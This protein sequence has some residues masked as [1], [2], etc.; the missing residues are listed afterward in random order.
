MRYGLIK[1]LMA[2]KRVGLLL[3]V[4]LMLS[5]MLRAADVEYK[6]ETVPNVQLSDARRFVTNPDGVLSQSAQDSVDIMLHQLKEQGKAQVAVVAVNSIGLDEPRDFAHKLLNSWG[7]GTKGA[8]NGLMVL[9]VVDQGAIEI[10]TGYGVEGILPDAICKRVITNIMIPRF[11]EGDFSGGMVE[12]MSALSAILD[13]ADPVAVVG[14][15]ENEDFTLADGLALLF[16]FFVCPVGAMVLIAF[17]HNRC[18]KCKEHKLKR[19]GERILL[20]NNAY[21]K[22]YKV[23]YVCG[24]CG[25]VVWRREAVNKNNGGIGGAGGVGGFGGGRG[26]GGGG[27]F[28]GG[29]GGGMSGGG[30]AGGRF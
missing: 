6:V 4:L 21:Q 28:G 25:H 15:D 27:S 20:S 13:G 9:L 19:S 24:N 29:W 14:E 12:G 26:F 18:P 1:P 5:P 8:D 7:L 16:V 23:P 3:G 22:V 30:G 11:K 2:G 10:E 17:F